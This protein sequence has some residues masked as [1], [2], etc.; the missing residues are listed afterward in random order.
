VWS[1]EESLRFATIMVA[2]R[3][4]SAAQRQSALLSEATKVLQ[5]ATIP[6]CLL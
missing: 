6:V 4:F 2:K 1:F 5:N 3:S